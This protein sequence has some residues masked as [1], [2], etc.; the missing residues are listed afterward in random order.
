MVSEDRY[1][2]TDIKEY[3]MTFEN[4]FFFFFFGGFKI[5][6]VSFYTIVYLVFIASPS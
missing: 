1:N 3:F 4:I 2:V 6:D 5:I